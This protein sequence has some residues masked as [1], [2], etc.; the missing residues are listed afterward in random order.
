MGLLAF[1]VVVLA[2]F[3]TRLW[4][5]AFSSYPFNNDGLTECSIAA[6]ILSSGHFNVFPSGIVQT[7]HSTAIPAMN[8]VI[9]YASCALGVN[10]YEFGQVLTAV[11]SVL[12]ISGLY[13]LGR[14]FS[15]DVRGGIA[16]SLA[17]LLMGT[18]VFTTG[19]VWKEAFGFGMILLLLIGFVRRDEARFRIMC[20]AILI[21]I[22]LV[23]HLIAVIALLMVAYPVALE[24]MFALFRRSVRH[25]HIDDLVMVVASSIWMLV[26]YSAASMGSFQQ[27]VS[28]RTIPV[29]LAVFAAL[30]LLQILPQSVRKHTKL[31]FAPAPGIAIA[32]LLVL[33]YSGFLFPYTPAAPT[34]YFLL[35]ASFGVLVSVAWYGTEYAFEFVERYRAVQLGLLLSPM[36]VI[37]L[38]IMTGLTAGAGRTIYRSFDSVDVFIFIGMGLAITS[39]VRFRK[40]AYPVLA[41]LMIVF[42]AISFPFGYYSEQML[43]VRHDTQSYEVDA[44]AW[45]SKSQ[46]N[47]TLVSDERLAY[48]SAAVVGMPAGAGLVGALET[49]VPLPNHWFFAFDD[50]YLTSGVNAFPNGHPLIPISNYTN[51]IRASDVLYIGGPQGDRITIMSASDIGWVATY[52]QLASS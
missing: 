24:W 40:R 48:V 15:G 28:M 52:P 43:G 31:T 22:P 30:A 42:V 10:T 38:G 20:M 1:L 17:G 39:A 51:L 27:V 50:S 37:V 7:T 25:R 6:Q 8:I 4:P 33:D 46:L 16:A 49:D 11:M 12:T 13:V 36:T 35:I 18:F 2:A 29:I 44:L 45:L 26:Y 14:T 3:L 5:L 32:V 23:H 19:S 21:V 34:V 9:A 47:V 41:A